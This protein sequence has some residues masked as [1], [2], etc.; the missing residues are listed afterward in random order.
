MLIVTV[1][2]AVFGATSFVGPQSGTNK[3][4]NVSMLFAKS[5]RQNQSL[6]FIYLGC[7]W[8]TYTIIVRMNS[9]FKKVFHAKFWETCRR[10]AILLILIP[11]S[12]SIASITSSSHIVLYR[13]FLLAI[14][15]LSIPYFSQPFK[16]TR[17]NGWYLFGNLLWFSRQLSNFLDKICVSFKL[18]IISTI[19]SIWQL[20][21]L[22]LQSNFYDWLL[23]LW[24]Q[25][26]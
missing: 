21:S 16:N 8:C 25:I 22:L 12:S 23:M 24:T 5:S 3:V 10:V 7:K 15:R 17:P 19:Q 6:Y 18:T 14:W 11:D 2:D 20:S 26:K 1:I 9:L 4:R 13:N